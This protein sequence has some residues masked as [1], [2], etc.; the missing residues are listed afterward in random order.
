MPRPPVSAAPLPPFSALQAR[1][2]PGDF[3]DCYSVVA[4]L[5]PRRAAE[6][7]TRFPAWV[8]ILMLLRGLA[9]LPFGLKQGVPEAPDHVGGFPVVSETDRELTAGFD[10]KHLDFRISVTSAGG[11]VALATWVRPHNPAGRLYLRM[12]LPF[13]IAISRDALARVGCEAGPATA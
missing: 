2:L 7:I 9:T 4:D 1:L 10:D 6:I 13:H 12:I 5:P 8:R 11:Q 3:I